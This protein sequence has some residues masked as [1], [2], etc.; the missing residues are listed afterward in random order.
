[1]HRLDDAA[2][3]RSRLG[4]TQVQRVVDGVGQQ[5][6]G[7]HHRRHVGVL[8]R[9]LDVGEVHLLEQ[10]CLPES[11]LHERLW[12]RR[13]VLLEQLL[14]QRAGIDADAYGDAPVLRLPG[15]GL[16]VLFLA[17]VPGIEPQTL[18]AGFDGGQRQP[19][20]I[21][22]VGDDRNR[23]ARD[24]LG[25]TLSGLHLVAGDADDVGAR[26]C[27]GVHLSQR[28]VDVGRFRG[29]H[30]LDR[31]GCATTDGNRAD[32]ELTCGATL[33]CH[34]ANGTAGDRA[35]RDWEGWVRGVTPYPRLRFAWGADPGSRA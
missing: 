11:G 35:S 27:E 1:G 16:D 17:D 13:P 25:E 31:D 32:V 18:H 4:D 8:H 23:A 14:G 12:P 5:A 33:D 24:D 34:G 26:S 6:V 7:L 15:D 20:L 29:R 9:D 21:V 28:A 30:R 3:R 19:V 2:R 22:D 10:T